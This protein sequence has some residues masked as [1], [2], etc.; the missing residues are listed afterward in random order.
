ML[1]H[2]LI[3]TF[4][5]PVRI[6]AGKPPKAGSIGNHSKCALFVTCWNVQCW[7]FNILQLFIM[8]RVKSTLLSTCISHCELRY[9]VSVALL[10]SF[11]CSVLFC[12]LKPHWWKIICVFVT[13]SLWMSLFFIVIPKL[14]LMYLNA[15]SPCLVVIICNNKLW[16]QF[17][18]L[19]QEFTCIDCWFIYC[20]LFGFC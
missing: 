15:S 7:G 12:K 6:Q 11:L 3:M 14:I 18:L 17:W 19:E 1:S 10:L 2:W 9:D 8:I 4:N 20:V 5:W 16:M 13:L